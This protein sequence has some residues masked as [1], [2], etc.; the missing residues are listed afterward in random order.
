MIKPNSVMVD[1]KEEIHSE[2]DYYIAHGDQW[3]NVGPD[4]LEAQRHEGSVVEQFRRH[5]AIH[6]RSNA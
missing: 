1:E 4:A 3:I 5:P 2:G 6:L